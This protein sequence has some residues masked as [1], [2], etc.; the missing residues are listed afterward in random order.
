MHV[1]TTT[2]KFIQR[3][4]ASIHAALGTTPEGLIFQVYT[5]LRHDDEAHHR[6]ETSNG[7]MRYSTTHQME[8]KSHGEYV[9][10]EKLQD[11][12]LGM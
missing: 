9:K 8:E 1:K 2:K 3:A 4:V 5:M 7:P 6:F 12:P 10:L 11:D